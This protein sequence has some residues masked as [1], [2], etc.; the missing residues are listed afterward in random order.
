MPWS[1]RVLIMALVTALP[2]ASEP[3]M[4]EKL[5]MYMNLTARFSSTGL[6]G[7]LSVSHGSD[8][9]TSLSRLM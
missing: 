8:G 7:T 6:T 3:L 5:S 9:R 4:V 1:R 2:S